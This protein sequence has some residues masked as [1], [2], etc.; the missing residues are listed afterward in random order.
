M[1]ERCRSTVRTLRHSRS[2]IASFV[3]P[4]AT[5]SSTSSSR[6]LSSRDAAGR[7][8]AGPV[9]RNAVELGDEVLPCRLVGE[10]D[11]IR[12]LEQDQAAPGIERGEQPPL[13]DRDDA[14]VAGSG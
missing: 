13:L 9:P 2:A 6:A 3:S 10:Q 12:R 4:A 14:V 7:A 5:S 8:A 11:V 1:F